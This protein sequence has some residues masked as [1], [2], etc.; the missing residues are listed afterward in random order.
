MFT[1]ITEAASAV[2][3]LTA[4][5]S[6]AIFKS[7]SAFSNLM[8]RLTGPSRDQLMA[9]V[10]KDLKGEYPKESLDYIHFM[11]RTRMFGEKE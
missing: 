11:V 2:S 8:D 10:V 3:P 4:A 9:N 7:I 6:S 1:A 5:I